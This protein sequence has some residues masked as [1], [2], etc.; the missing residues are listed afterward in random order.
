[1]AKI[2]QQTQIPASPFP[3]VIAGTL[4]KGKENYLTIGAYGG[5]SIQ[6]PMVYISSMKAHYSNIG[7]KE[8]G[9]FSINLPPAGLVRETDYCGLVSGRDIDKSRLFT[10]F[11]GEEK[12]APMVREC[13]VNAV[14]RLEKTVD[15]P[16]NDV[17][18]GEVVEYYVDDSCLDGKNPDPGK[19]A[20]LLLYGR[21]YRRLGRIAGT[22]FAA[23]KVLMKKS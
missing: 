8:T 21:S 19:T 22:A 5:M 13:P 9:Y 18:I 23:G 15:L 16:S 17:F 10:P 3:I 12:L 20:P 14:C 11:Y 4:V 1:M 2:Q 7:I 6:P